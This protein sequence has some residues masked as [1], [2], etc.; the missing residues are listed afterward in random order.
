MELNRLPLASVPEN[1]LIAFLIAL[2]ILRFL[3]V[4]AELQ[5][6]DKQLAGARFDTLQARIKPHFLFNTLNSIATLISIRPQDAETALL[7]LSDMMRSSISRENTAWTLAEEVD[8]CK[9]YLGIEKLRMGDRL[10]WEIDVPEQVGAIRFPQLALQPLVENAVLHGVQGSTEG[11]SLT[12][13]VQCEND[14]L[15]IQLTN[16][17]AD[18][19]VEHEGLGQALVNTRARLEAYFNRTRRFHTGRE[20][21]N[22]VVHIELELQP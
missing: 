6:R 5:R 2:V 14:V 11:G 4:H 1:T 8:I 19:Q 9:K 13:Q 3:A 21:N 7:D 16:T 22:F 17:C 15:S 20:A 12:L 18:A 10:S